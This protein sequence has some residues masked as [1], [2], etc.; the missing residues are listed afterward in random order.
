[1]IS[2]HRM[3]QEESTRLGIRSPQDTTTTYASPRII[4][5]AI[6]Q[7]QYSQHST[8]QVT[9]CTNRAY[10]KNGNINPSAQHAPTAYT[11]PNPASQK[12]SSD[13]PENSGPASSQNSKSQAQPY[14]A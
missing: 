14:Q 12:T 4:T 9:H 11:N 10:R 6:S 13:A 1:M 3:L 8:K 2:P 5:Q 7:A